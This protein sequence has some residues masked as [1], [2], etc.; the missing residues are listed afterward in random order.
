MKIAF[1]GSSLVSAFWNGAATYYRGIIRA[2]ADRGHDV[3][4]YEPDAFDR[5]LHRDMA[6]P[7]WATVVLYSPTLDAVHQMIER[8]RGADLVVKASGVG[9]HDAVLEAAVLTLQ[10]ARTL[11]AFWDVDA[12]ATLDRLEQDPADPFRALI[13]RYDLVFTYGGGA[14][15]TTAYER[16]GARRCVPIYNA[17]DP[18]THYP[19]PAEH[20]FTGSLGFLG[21]RLPDREKRVDEFFLSA[22]VRLPGSR[23]L[24]GGAG[25]A[26]KPMPSNVSYLGHVYTR[27]HNA[28]NTSPLAVLNVSRDSM[29][30]YGF[31]PATRVFEAAGAGACLITDAWTG[32][33]QFLE[34]GRE[35]LVAHDGD[36]V[37]HHV[38]TLTAP[39][40][41]EIGRRAR[42]RMLQE[43]TY[44]HRALDV[45]AALEDR[46][47]S[48]RA[49]IAV[50]V[51]DPDRPM[52]IVFLGLS[53]TSSWGNGHA[54]TYRGLVRELGERGH[55][56]TFL[57]R[58][59]PWYASH[60]DLAA[61]PYAKIGLYSTLEE[62]GERYASVVRDADLVIVGSY[63]PDGIE[64]G[65]WVTQTSRGV[66]AFYDIDTP[67]TLA[68]LASD[69]C[70]Y[71]DRALVRRFHMYLSFT[72]GPTLE[73]IEKELGSPRALPL[74]CSVDPA[75]YAPEQRPARWDLGYM[76]TYSA[77]R[78]RTLRS[79]LVDPARLERDRR[80]VIAGPQY[81][82]SLEWPSNVDRIEHLPPS[83]HRTFYNELAFT[84]NVT[85][86]DM[87]AAGWSPSVRLFEAA[88]CGVPIISDA[89]PGL[90]EL[91]TPDAEI[92]IARSTDDVLRYLRD[93]TD[94]QRRA[95]GARACARV[96][97]AHTAAHRAADLERYARA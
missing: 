30:A 2:L 15:V 45:E 74:Y 94:G 22:A 5:Q 4:F 20:R 62:L 21:N 96:R 72:G 43:H 49:P 31:S 9:I 3:T 41:R 70:E 48:R 77:D 89:W 68:R 12:P 91:F 52:S 18:S 61:P 25:W 1:F 37:A 76:G 16:L 66:T 26:D 17:L 57:E 86:A 93:L 27:E 53:I 92:L 42:A 13:R 56:V 79:L 73:R 82:A 81:P 64:I 55:H 51:P 83:D 34:P 7:P 88:A 24:L 6:D 84:L 33:E 58:D 44:A 29:A 50:P 80:F 78:Q 85:R 69:E 28:F 39:E 97:K 75:I 32:L 90:D 35:V 36:E 71:I 59:V 19:V 40:A 46:M 8:A 11:V 23:F 87:I 54:T 67:V 38:A 47:A 95:I 60:R 65:R 14:P 63:V 10:S